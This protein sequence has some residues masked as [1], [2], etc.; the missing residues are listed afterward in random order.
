MP[1]LNLA[2]IACLAGL[3]LLSLV[4]PLMLSVSGNVEKQPA[5]KIVWVGQLLGALA[6]LSIVFFP[7]SY[8]FATS[9]A[10][11]SCFFC[12]RALRRLQNAK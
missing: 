8:L 6:G 10:G 9:F 4:L 12:A 1:E 5:L 11:T 2:Q 7:T 3:V